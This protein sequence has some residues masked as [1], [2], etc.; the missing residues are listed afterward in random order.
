MQRMVLIF[1]KALVLVQSLASTMA[2][3]RSSSR[4]RSP[5]PP[6]RPSSIVQCPAQEVPSDDEQEAVGTDANYDPSLHQES[7]LSRP[8][9]IRR[10]CRLSSCSSNS[11]G[12]TVGTVDPEPHSRLLGPVHQRSKVKGLWHVVVNEDCAQ[13]FKERYGELTIL[14]ITQTDITVRQQGSLV[15]AASHQAHQAAAKSMRG[16]S[17]IRQGRSGES[18]GSCP[19]MGEL[20]INLVRA[21]S[22]YG[23]IN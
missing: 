16:S 23:Q 18:G 15:P 9:N 5:A 21:N 3:E 6:H 2:P 20:S 13:Q 19:A 8:F 12:L 7:H 1:I 4:S 11:R 17:H 14:R 10:H 22:T